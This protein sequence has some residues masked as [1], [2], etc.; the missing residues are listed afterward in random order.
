MKMFRQPGFPVSL[1]IP[2]DHI[3]HARATFDADAIGFIGNPDGYRLGI[4]RRTT[5]NT[6]DMDKLRRE[7]VYVERRPY[8]GSGFFCGP[9]D[10]YFSFHVNRV[11]LPEPNISVNEVFD[12]YVN[13]L[14]D[15]ILG[16]GIQAH[17][18][19]SSRSKN[20]NDGIC[21]N[22]SGRSEI[23]DQYGN[24]LVAGVF[25]DDGLVISM[26]GV[27]LVS[28]DWRKI[29]TYL[30][31]PPPNQ[32][33]GS[34]LEQHVEDDALT[35]RVIQSVCSHFDVSEYLKLTPKDYEV[36]EQ[37]VANFRVV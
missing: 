32:I 9:K 25:K 26:S 6:F 14:L 22:L 17:I 4:G 13:K 12:Q 21:M 10:V 33:S 15:V 5:P 11:S 19:G 29:Y 23:V 35:N 28:D 7:G 36:L 24:K 18:Q 2:L 16:L 1:A 8:G 37:L 27:F 3:I 30:R 34:S 31:Q 20:R